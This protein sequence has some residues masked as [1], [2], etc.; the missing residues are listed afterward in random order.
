MVV[1]REHNEAEAETKNGTGQD[2][3]DGAGKVL[4]FCSDG[5]KEGRQKKPG[6]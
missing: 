6:R 3:K 2:K 5:K 1:K 4:I